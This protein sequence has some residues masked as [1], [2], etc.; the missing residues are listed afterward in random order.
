MQARPH[1]EQ[2]QA[3]VALPSPTHTPT[4]SW[5]EHPSN[6]KCEGLQKMGEQK[7]LFSLKMRTQVPKACVFSPTNPFA[8]F[9]QTK[10]NKCD[11]FKGTEDLVDVSCFKFKN[12]KIKGA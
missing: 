3:G 11:C 7:Y 6:V 12:K 4:P 2:I 9:Q 8:V 10:Y 5:W 1:T